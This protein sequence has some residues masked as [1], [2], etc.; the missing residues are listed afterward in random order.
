MKKELIVIYTI[1]WIAA[2]SRV[3]VWKV[4]CW[5]G[6]TEGVETDESTGSAGTT[7][8]PGYRTEMEAREGLDFLPITPTI[9]T[10]LVNAHR[11]WDRSR[12]RQEG[13]FICSFPVQI[14]DSKVDK[15]LVSA[16]TWVLLHRSWCWNQSTGWGNK[17]TWKQDSLV[18][19]SSRE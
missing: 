15:E 11:R 12:N 3:L 7:Q 6:G 19:H 18:V 2:S 8:V 5:L 10:G 4:C 14:R 9:R 13:R 16:L 1:R 17:K